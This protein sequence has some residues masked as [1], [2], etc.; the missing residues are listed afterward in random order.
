M[1][2]LEVLNLGD[3]LLK[4]RGIIQLADVLSE[5][6]Q[7]LRELMFAYNEVDADGA[8]AVAEAMEKKSKLEKLD[9]N[10]T[11]KN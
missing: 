2:K 6:H 4:S 10:G 8:I 9:L 1:Q 7:E 11:G 3:C 5:G